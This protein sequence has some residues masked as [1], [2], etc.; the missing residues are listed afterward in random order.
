L[1]T[2]LGRYILREVVVN[3]LVVTAVLLII[4]LA[5]QV[6]TVLERAAA[7]QFPQGVVLQL[8]GLGALQNLSVLLPVGLLLGVVLA[9]GRLYHDS[10]M[11]AAFAC[12]VG[13]GTI[14]APVGLLAVVVSV[15]LAWLTLVQA[16]QAMER[17]LNLR[18]EA[19]RAGQFAPIAPGK[20][21]SFGGG[22]AVV[23]AQDVNSDGTLANVFISRNT[24]PQVEVALAGRARHAVSSDGMTHI[25]TLYDGERFEGVPGSPEFRIVRFAE[26]VVPVQVPALPD[27]GRRLEAQPTSQLLRSRDPDDQG[28]LH[29]RLALPMM[30][31]VLALVAVPLSRLQ[32]RQ[33]RYARVWVAV[34]IYFLYSNLVSVGKVWISHGKAPEWLGLW[35]THVVVV[36][37]ALLVIAWPGLRN[38]LRYRARH[39]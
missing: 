16:P 7:N 9:F 12:G 27:I 19:L 8:I 39:A 10:E 20:F 6:F 3:W 22:S 30:C 1:G 17:A 5:N 34:L 26:H 33:G 36:L 37:L 28:E 4:L 25:L 35:W 29:W 24:G 14:Y 31:L 15:L 11:A 23:Y 18:N 38:R 32:P 21:R 2:I 13:P